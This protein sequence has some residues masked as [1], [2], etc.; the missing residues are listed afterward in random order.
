MTKTERNAA[1]QSRLVLAEQ[2][3]ALTRA[4]AVHEEQE[5]AAAELDAYLTSGQASLAELDAHTTKWLNA[6]AAE[7]VSAKLVQGCEANVKRAEAALVKEAY[8]SFF[9]P[10]R[11][12]AAANL[13]LYHRSESRGPLRGLA[14][15]SG[16][17]G[18]PRCRS[19]AAATVA[20]SMIR[21][22]TERAASFS[23]ASCSS[24]S[25]VLWI[26]GLRIEP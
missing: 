5:T 6:V 2:K 4:E 24:H 3:T 10:P 7:Q 22:R 21:A 18:Y 17:I 12:T 11:F 13:A 1:E 15:A 19:P 14:A 25:S 8:Q 23:R 20:P 26:A 9:M 16:A